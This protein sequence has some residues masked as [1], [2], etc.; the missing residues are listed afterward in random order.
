MNHAM[1]PRISVIIPIYNTQKYLKKCINSILTQSMCN[2]ELLL[3]DDGS[4]DGSDLIAKEFASMD[5]R[6]EY[7]WQENQGQA[8]ARN[9]GIKRA[10]GEFISFIDSDDWIEPTML[11]DMLNNLSIDDFDFVT[12][13]LSFFKENDPLKTDIVYGSDYNL[14]ILSGESILWNA[15]RGKYVTSSSVN[16]VFRCSFLLDNSIYFPENMKNED[17]LFIITAASKAKKVSFLNKAYYHALIREGSTTRKLTSDIL[18]STVNSLV[19]EQKYLKDIGLYEQHH[20][21]HEIHYIMLLNYLLVRAPARANDIKKWYSIIGT[22]EY[23]TYLKKNIFKISLVHLL[24]GILCRLH[25]LNIL[26][27]ISKKLY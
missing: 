21:G 27:P 5:K 2:F 18:N 22:T 6:I 3:I 9:N 24:C 8:V 15:L 1:N 12:C 19:F 7:I 25:L 23:Y 14:T 13:R 10:R 4:T 16:K 20:I 11:E 17:V 26:K